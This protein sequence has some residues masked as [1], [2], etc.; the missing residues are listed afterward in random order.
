MKIDSALLQKTAQL[1]RL[2][3]K[4]ECEATLLKDLGNILTWVEKL[5]EVDTTHVSPLITI[6]EARSVAA[7]DIPVP[8]LSHEQALKNAPSRDSNYFRVPQ[9][10]E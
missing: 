9:V 8:P 4:E 10:K 5:S 7:E 6:T 3:I 1:A 2:E